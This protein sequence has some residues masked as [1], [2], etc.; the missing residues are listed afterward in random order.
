MKLINESGS[1]IKVIIGIINERPNNSKIPEN[2]NKP[3]IRKNL[4]F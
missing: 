2:N 1:K 3:I 4:N